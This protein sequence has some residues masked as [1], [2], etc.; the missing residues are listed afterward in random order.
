M[1][2][3]SKSTGTIIIVALIALLFVALNPSTDDFK[4][5]RSSQA[6]SRA[7]RSD[8][9]G[10]VGALKSG[11]G[12]IAGAVAGAMA[13]GYERQNYYL[14]STYSLGSDRYLGVAHLFIKLK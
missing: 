9:T 1:A 4:V 13:G 6:E 3:T 10:L 8:T 2:K 11:A 14:F 5:W 12:A 7:A